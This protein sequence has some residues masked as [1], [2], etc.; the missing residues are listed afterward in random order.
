MGVE[1]EEEEGPVWVQGGNQHKP[2]SMREGDSYL[3][4]GVASCSPPVSLV[5]ALALT[6]VEVP[7]GRGGHSSSFPLW[8]VGPTSRLT[9][10]P[11]SE[12]PSQNTPAG[13][14][15]L[16]VV[17]T[18]APQLCYEPNWMDSA[19]TTGPTAGRLLR[20][21]WCE[22]GEGRKLSKCGWALPLLGC[23]VRHGVQEGY[24]G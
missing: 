21:L 3:W 10:T 6:S 9:L 8:D 1:E 18:G 11:T 17:Q 20:Q 2:E 16:P 4:V 24:V 23:W 7:V 22:E 19:S 14:L 15:W 12:K 5:P 13:C